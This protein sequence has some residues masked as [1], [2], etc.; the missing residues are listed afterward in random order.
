MWIHQS[1][2]LLMMLMMITAT[3]RTPLALITI[4]HYRVIRRRHRYR[5]LKQ[6]QN[7]LVVVCLF[8]I[9][10]QL[11]GPVAKLAKYSK[12][13]DIAWIQINRWSGWEPPSWAQICA[14]RQDSTC[15]HI[16]LSSR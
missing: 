16:N 14:P 3:A 13:Y 8:S 5:S 11:G 9:T 12:R 7:I 4:D 2:V 1:M 10:I 6:Y 15:K